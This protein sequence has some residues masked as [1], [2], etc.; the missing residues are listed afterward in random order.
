MGLTSRLSH[1]NI[2]FYM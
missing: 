2:G 1:L